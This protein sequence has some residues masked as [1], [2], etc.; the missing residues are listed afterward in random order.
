VT[1]KVTKVRPEKDYF[2]TLEFSNG[3]V[4]KFDVKPYLSKGIFR[5]LKD[6]SKF[7]TVHTDGLSIEWANEA[8]LCPDTVYF[9]SVQ[10]AFISLTS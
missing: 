10:I 4:R 8:S 9:N 1:P 5:E 7:N 6:L 3:D 2:L